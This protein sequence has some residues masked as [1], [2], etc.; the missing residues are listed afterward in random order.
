MVDAMVDAR[1]LTDTAAQWAESVHGLSDVLW[2][3]TALL[4]IICLL[5]GFV[6]YRMMCPPAGES[7][8]AAAPTEQSALIGEKK[9][10]ED[11]KAEGA[12]AAAEESEGGAAAAEEKEGGA[13]SADSA[14]ADAAAAAAAVVAGGGDDKDAQVSCW[15]STNPFAQSTHHHHR[16]GV[17]HGTLG[18]E[19]H[20]DEEIVRENRS[21]RGAS[22]KWM[23]VIVKGVIAALLAG[24]SGYIVY[25]GIN[26]GEVDYSTMYMFKSL[27]F[28]LSVVLTLPQLY[29]TTLMSLTFVAL[30]RDAIFEELQQTRH[31]CVAFAI[32]IGLTVVV[33]VVLPL[34]LVGGLLCAPLL[35]YFGVTDLW[36]VIVGLID[37]MQTLVLVP[38]AY[39]VVFSADA[40]PDI[41]VNIVAVQVFANLDDA[42]VEAF[43]NPA[44]CKYEAL[45][46]YCEKENDDSDEK[47]AAERAELSEEWKAGAKPRVTALAIKALL[48]SVFI[49]LSVY[50]AYDT[51][52]MMDFSEM[53]VFK[54]LMVALTM[55]QLVPQLYETTLMTLTFFAVAE[56]RLEAE[57]KRSR[58][59]HYV[60]LIGLVF[61]LTAP[62][63]L[64]LLV[65]FGP[66]INACLDKKSQVHDYWIIIIGLIDALQTA[67]LFPLAF[68]FMFSA[69]APTDTFI[70]L[71]VILV[72]ARLDDDVVEAFDNV[73]DQK[74]EI[75]ETYCEKKV[76]VCFQK[77]QRL[78]RALDDY[79]KTREALADAEA[80]LKAAE[81]EVDG[82]TEAPTE[83]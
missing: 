48:A 75:L 39:V 35:P 29:Q 54:A 62:L 64:P 43:A 19:Y 31:P 47:K 61:V 15:E 38:L 23:P 7:A 36:L 37:Y 71:V 26:K 27:A 53:T 33:P 72:F 67:V 25:D 1:R 78:R 82:P 34:L 59:P 46:T 41:F 50:E 13:A 80:E 30:G 68:V 6:V 70:Y 21:W 45:E 22:I 77:V 55:V 58:G 3:D 2:I 4:I 12:S 81:E 20:T 60:L 76:D 65:V 10:A 9:P 63:T 17:Y 57:L 44:K 49:A 16:H 51:W 74:I 24:F 5:V 42:F 79:E 83:N 8:A 73:H 28:A 56:D 11:G 69:D 40:P 66:C 32:A 52:D 14:D 18:I